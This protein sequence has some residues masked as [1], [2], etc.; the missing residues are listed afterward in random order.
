MKA[1]KRILRYLKGTP[2]LVLFYPTSDNFDLVD[3]EDKNFAGYLVDRKKTSEIVYFLG[4][5]L[6]SSGTKKQNSLALS[7]TETEYMATALCCARLF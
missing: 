5:S 2:D 7:T 6:I 4:S 1:V 3:Y